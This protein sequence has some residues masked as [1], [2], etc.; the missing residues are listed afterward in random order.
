M[1]PKRAKQ[2]RGRPWDWF[3]IAA[4]LASILAFVF[5]SLTTVS[6]FSR[7]PTP[8]PPVPDPPHQMIELLKVPRNMPDGEVGPPTHEI[9]GRVDPSPPP[10]SHIV[11][12]S[13]TNQWYVQPYEDSYLTPVGPDGRWK[14]LIRGGSYYLSLLVS[15]GFQAPS[16]SQGSPNALPNVL[17]WTL[18]EGRRGWYET[19]LDFLGQ[20]TGLWASLA[21][22]ALAGFAVL[23]WFRRR[24]S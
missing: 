7:Q 3:Q 2:Q 21:I 4:N 6:L 24:R 20:H 8:A 18:T 12:Y 1:L 23:F 11:V 22:I 13:Y 9:E 14:T 19:A 15:E 17:T 5:G 16:P 10:A